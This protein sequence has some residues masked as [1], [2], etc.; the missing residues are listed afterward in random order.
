MVEVKYKLAP[1]AQVREEDF[2]LLFYNMHGPRLYFLAS[3][4]LLPEKFF[5]GRIPLDVW[6]DKIHP[7]SRN[8]AMRVAGL[9]KSLKKLAEKGV[10]I[11][12]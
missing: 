9:K 11:E 6:I 3:G 5:E 10:I 2:G 12:C 8:I 7:N 1:G 4:S